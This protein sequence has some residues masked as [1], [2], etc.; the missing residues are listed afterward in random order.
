M[1]AFVP[2]V[3]TR[4]PGRQLR[5]RLRQRRVRT[6]CW[7]RAR[8]TGRWCSLTM[9]TPGSNPDAWTTIAYTDAI[10]HEKRQ[11]WISDAQVAEIPSTAFTSKPKAEGVGAAGHHREQP[12]A[13]GLTIHPSDRTRP[14]PTV[15][16]T[17]PTRP[18]RLA[19]SHPAARSR[20]PHDHPRCD[21]RSRLSVDEVSDLR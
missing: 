15:E 11:R 21:D 8:R 20:Q 10:F 5:R 7:R 19:L 14:E 17:R 6:W 13:C 12:A 18:S 9:A 16:T 2:A 1:S 3:D 4:G